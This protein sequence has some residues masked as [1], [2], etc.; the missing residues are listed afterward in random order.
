MEGTDTPS[1]FQQL[2]CHVCQAGGQ[3]PVCDNGAAT[4]EPYDV[5]SCKCVPSAHACTLLQQWGSSVWVGRIQGPR[6]GSVV[7]D[8][9]LGFVDVAI[10][11]HTVVGNP[12]VGGSTRRLCE[13][14]DGLLQQIL[15]GGI[16]DLNQLASDYRR[17]C[18]EQPLAHSTDEHL[19]MMVLRAIAAQHRVQLHKRYAAQFRLAHA[20]AWLAHHTQLLMAGQSLR[21]LCHCVE[22]ASPL[23]SC[24]GQ[25]LAGAL[26]WVAGRIR[27]PTQVS[28]QP[29][30]AVSHPSGRP[31]LG[32]GPAHA[33][34]LTSFARVTRVSLKGWPSARRIGS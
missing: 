27:S 28:L 7:P 25:G 3:P 5:M 20:K 10:D 34:T 31:T 4:S 17:L 29:L 18:D 32:V 12:F 8:A 16:S 13:A 1:C 15:A 14:F 24:H 21:L 22:G 9:A 11:R 33:W 30:T 6:P 2:A 26:T 23:G 19:D